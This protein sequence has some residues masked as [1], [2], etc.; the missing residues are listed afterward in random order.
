MNELVI[1]LY[2]LVAF[3][4]MLFLMIVITQAMNDS[5]LRRNDSSWVQTHRKRAFY[6]AAAYLL[7]T[8]CIQDYWLVHPTVVS[9]GLVVT[10]LLLGSNWILAVNSI[11]LG[12]RV[13]PDHG[14]RM[15]NPSFGASSFVAKL[16]NLFRM[17]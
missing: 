9:V 3:A 5:L 1:A 15:R 11:S 16:T 17:H 12:S 14:S 6:G 10:G 8:I 13:P 2:D 4:G 7:L